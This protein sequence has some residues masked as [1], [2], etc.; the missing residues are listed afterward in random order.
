MELKRREKILAGAVAVLLAALA[1]YYALPLLLRG[2]AADREQRNKL[3]AEVQKKQSRIALAEKATTQLRQWERQSL[4]SDKEV[5]SSLYQ[6]WLTRLVDEFKFRRSR[7]EPGEGRSHRG[8]YTAFSFTIRGHATLRELVP[9]LYAFYSAG[10]L[11]QVRSLSCKPTEDSKD[12]DLVIS[13][14]ALMLPGADR[15]DK[16]SQ[17]PGVRLTSNAVAA[18]E[19]I[20]LER[21][22]FV[23]FR[24]L[25]VRP[26]ESKQPSFDASKYAYLTGITFRNGSAEAWF[27]LRTTGGALQ[28]R[29]GDAL[30]VGPLKGK[31]LRIGARDAEV[32]LSNGTRAVFSLGKS[33]TALDASGSRS[34]TPKDGAGPPVAP[35]VGDDRRSGFGDAGRDRPGES[36]RSGRSR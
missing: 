18:Y 20:I 22:P 6:N 31:V 1:A 4:P 34:E 36:G 13:I 9:F 14:E 33:L 12:L 5:A 23:P 24:P 7:V 21:D 15:S 3:A 29:E 11:H 17:E 2:T 26:A 19:K 30:E 10:H 27:V 25:D 16:L 32:E 35:P 8:V 28:L